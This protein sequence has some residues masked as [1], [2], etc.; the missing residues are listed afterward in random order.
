MK[1]K[2]SNDG[3]ELTVTLVGEVDAANV[4]VIEEK[5]LKE[6]AGVTDL[7]FDLKELEY[8]SSAGLRV[9]LQMQ[10]MM[11]TQ[12]NMVIINTNDEVMD[13]FKVTGFVRLLNIV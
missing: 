6:V 4:T 3:S 7:T 11:K 10:K 5:L 12:G 9:L 13:I 1:L 8:I 2:K